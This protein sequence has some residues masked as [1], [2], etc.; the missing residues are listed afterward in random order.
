[1]INQK[2]GM[3]VE[4]KF[5][6]RLDPDTEYS[7]FTGTP[8]AMLAE[9]EAERKRFKE[10]AE[11]Q[12]RAIELEEPMMLHYLERLQ[13]SGEAAALDWLKARTENEAEGE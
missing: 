4:R 13:L 8:A 5:L 12:K 9:L 6:E 3:S 10:L 7:Y 2:I 1:V 11:Y